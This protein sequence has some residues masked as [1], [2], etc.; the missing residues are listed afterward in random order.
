MFNS[1]VTGIILAGAVA[2]GSAGVAQAGRQ[3]EP[4]PRQAPATQTIVQI[5]MDVNKTGEF[6]YLSPQPRAP[7]RRRH[8]RPAERL[9][10]VHVVRAHR[11]GVRG[12]DPG[13]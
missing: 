13:P 5:A 6:D 4:R 1:K 9:C 7:I 11:R 2:I 8:R 10:E 3:E 12:A